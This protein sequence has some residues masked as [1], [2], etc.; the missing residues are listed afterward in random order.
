MFS[1]RSSL[2]NLAAVRPLACRLSDPNRRTRR[3]LSSEEQ[4]LAV[5]W[6]DD[7]EK[8]VARCWVVATSNTMAAA[9]RTVPSRER[10]IP[11]NASA[12]IVLARLLVSH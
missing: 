6:D 9:A 12:I 10:R 4:H 2:G 7:G 3:M 8:A 1:A 5:R 11:N